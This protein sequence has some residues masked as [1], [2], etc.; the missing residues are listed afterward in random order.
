MF[1]LTTLQDCTKGEDQKFSK[2]YMYLDYS[3]PHCQWDKDKEE[4]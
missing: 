3:T 1:K 2:N 4:C